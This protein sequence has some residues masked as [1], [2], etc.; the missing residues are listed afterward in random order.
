MFCSRNKCASKVMH[1]LCISVSSLLQWVNDRLHLDLYIV[2]HRILL[3]AFISHRRV[4][5]KEFSLFLSLAILLFI[6]FPVIRHQMPNNATVYM[7]KLIFYL[8]RWRCAF[9]LECAHKLFNICTVVPLT[10]STVFEVQTE[11]S[12]SKLAA[13]SIFLSLG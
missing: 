9:T 3:L 6:A 8:S 12:S 1:H 10:K 5:R 4:R 13:L 7:Q 11:S 2:L